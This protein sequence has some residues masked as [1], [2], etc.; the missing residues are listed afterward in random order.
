MAATNAVA[1]PISTLAIPPLAGSQPACQAPK[2]ATGRRK[3]GKAVIG[4]A[5]RKLLPFLPFKPQAVRHGTLGRIGSQEKPV[6]KHFR[7]NSHPNDPWPSH[8]GAAR[9]FQSKDHPQERLCSPSVLGVLCFR[10]R[11]IRRPSRTLRARGVSAGPPTTSGRWGKQALRKP[12]RPVRIFRVF[13]G[14]TCFP[15]IPVEGQFFDRREID[16]RWSPGKSNR[17]AGAAGPL[18]NA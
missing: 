16:R 10:G 9:R 7:R 3:S 13:S 5:I 12:F 18:Q 14:K 11:V 2:R 17:H 4:S 8:I 15:E 6:P 1:A